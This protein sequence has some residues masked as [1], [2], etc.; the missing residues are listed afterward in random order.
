MNII[1]LKERDAISGNAKTNQVFSLFR[2]VIE[3]LKKKD[4]PREIIE[5]VNQDIDE[6]N[7]TSL[8][9]RNLRK[10][11]RQKQAKILK[12]F[13]KEL[14]IVP[15]NYYRNLWLAIGMGGIGTPIGV[16]VWLSTGILSFIGAGL[17]IGGVVGFALGAR[18][19]KKAFEEGRQLDIKLKH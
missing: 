19:D 5:S 10:F 6:I 17:P 2:K 14:K 8:T 3:E 18:M 16:A 4:L 12:R 1:E 15:K 7:S 11:V 9:D 13:E